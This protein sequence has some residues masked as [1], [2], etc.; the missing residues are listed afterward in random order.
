MCRDQNLISETDERTNGQTYE[1]WKVR[2]RPAPLGSGK[3]SL[4]QGSIHWITGLLFCLF[5]S[6]HLISW[7]LWNSLNVSNFCFKSPFSIFRYLKITFLIHA[8]APCQMFIINFTFT[9]FNAV[10]C[11]HFTFF[12]NSILRVNFSSCA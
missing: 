8:F 9:L 4:D 6:S 11:F 7:F 2:C 3:D 12:W 1:N 10:L 5:L